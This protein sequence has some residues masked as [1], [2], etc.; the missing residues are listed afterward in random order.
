V[1]TIPAGQQQMQTFC[2]AFTAAVYIVCMCLAMPVAGC[3]ITHHPWLLNS[4]L[5]GQQQMQTFL[6]HSQHQFTSYAYGWLCLWLA[7]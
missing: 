6:W 3:V 2:V 5:A 7:V 4:S 1:V